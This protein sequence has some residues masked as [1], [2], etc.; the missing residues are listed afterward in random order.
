MGCVGWYNGDM[1]RTAIIDT[2]PSD[3]KGICSVTISQ[4][5]RVVHSVD[6]VNY[7]IAITNIMQ[8]WDASSLKYTNRAKRKF[9]GDS[10]CNLTPNKV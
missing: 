2:L 3:P 8:E 4:D 10:S 1:K 6:W 9:L 5:N 7:G